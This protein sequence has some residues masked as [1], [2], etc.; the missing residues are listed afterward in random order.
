LPFI[1]VKKTTSVNTTKGPPDIKSLNML[2]TV[3]KK[4]PKDSLT[5]LEMGLAE[6]VMVT[7]NEE[8]LKMDKGNYVRAIKEGLTAIP[9]FSGAS[10]IPLSKVPANIPSKVLETTH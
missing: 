6:S 9:N 5:Q 4:T 7:Y 8:M 3:L 2:A 10:V 1:L